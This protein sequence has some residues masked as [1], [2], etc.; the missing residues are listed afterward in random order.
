MLK[1]EQRL[2]IEAYVIVGDDDMICDA[3]G[4]MPESLKNDADWGFFQSGLD[5]ADVCVLGRKNHEVSPNPKGRL[6]LVLTA[7]VSG[8]DSSGDAVFWNPADTSLDTALACFETKVDH[9]AVVGGQAVFD[10]F[11]SEPYRYTRFHLSRIAGVLIPNGRATFS[12]IESHPGLSAEDVLRQHGYSPKE[13]VTLD[14]D[15]ELVSWG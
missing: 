13:E 4:V 8:V 9:L 7:S 5:A 12:A 2:R 10:F 11:L 3:D 6:R 15:V 1:K 14:K